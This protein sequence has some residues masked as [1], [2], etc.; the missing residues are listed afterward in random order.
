MD[1]IASH[2]I[3]S[4]TSLIGLVVRSQLSFARIF[5]YQRRGF[6]FS[7]PSCVKVPLHA[8]LTDRCKLDM[9]LVRPALTV[10]LEPLL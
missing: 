6:S 2:G 4:R 3:A 10:F 7:A 5:K 8:P 1:P 9:L